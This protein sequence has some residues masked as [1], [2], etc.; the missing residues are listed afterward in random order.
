[1]SQVQDYIDK[2]KSEPKQP[3]PQDTPEYSGRRKR[4]ERPWQK[5]ETPQD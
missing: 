5:T 4:E 1:M 2:K 3:E